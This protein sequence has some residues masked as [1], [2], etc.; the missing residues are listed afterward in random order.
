MVTNWQVSC[1]QC[2]HMK[3]VELLEVVAFAK[4]VVQLR[5]LAAAAAAVEQ[6]QMKCWVLKCQTSWLWHFS[7]VL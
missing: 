4:Q 3:I 1:H 6:P 7:C 2:L 5:Q